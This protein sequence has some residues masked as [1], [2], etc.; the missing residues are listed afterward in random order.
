MISKFPPDFMWGAATSSH[1]VEGDNFYN[2]WWAWETS[3]YTEPSGRACDH[4]NR[5]REDFRLAK[6]IGHNVHRFSLEWSRLERENGKWAGNEWKHYSDVIN[7]LLRLG[8]EPV[9]TLNHF[10]LPLWL[11]RK[12]GWEN[13]NIIEHFSRF[14]EKA[15]LEYGG[16]VRYWITINEPLVL[17]FIGYF[18][19]EWPPGKQSFEEMLYVSRNMLKAHIAAYRKM[20]RAAASRPGVSPP[21]IGLAKAVTAFHPCS[22]ASIPDRI[23]AHLRNEFQNHA[24]IK[25]AMQG[26]IHFPPYVS[27]RLDGARALDF[28]GLNYYFREFVHH[29]SPLKENPFGWICSKAHHY[30]AGKRTEMGWEIY[31]KGIYEVIMDFRKYGLP[32]M[33]TENGISTY[34]DN[35]RIEYIKEHLRYILKA[36]EKGAPLKG[37]LHWSLL[38]NFEWAEG[39]KQ[40][41]GLAGVD[42]KTQERV[43]RGSARFLASVIERGMIP[44]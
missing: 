13:E 14:A 33:V 6:E 18:K 39:Y 31:P 12:G 37:Y 5:F 17:A 38:D 42:L 16:R 27:E 11:A 8:I 22:G 25:S 4:Y 15:V 35:V 34:D 2:D 21:A 43:V 1:Q 7:E 41:F 44:S 36:I 40:K 29:K 23:S 10:T 32:I 19:G 26:R 3:G 24:F 28:I 9:V 30:D 20:K